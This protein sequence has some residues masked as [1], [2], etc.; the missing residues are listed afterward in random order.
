MAVRLCHPYY[1]L[2]LTNMDWKRQLRSLTARMGGGARWQV[3]LEPSARHLRWPH[4]YAD[5][6][7]DVEGWKEEGNGGGGEV[8]DS[9]L[10]IIVGHLNV[11]TWFGRWQDER[12]WQCRARA[13]PLCSS[14]TWVWTLEGG[15]SFVG[16]GEGG[17]ARLVIIV[18]CSNMPTWLNVWQ[19]EGARRRQQWRS[20]SACHHRRPPQRAN[21]GWASHHRRSPQRANM[22]WM[23]AG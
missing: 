9:W 21:I 4:Q 10:V 18:G 23:L 2:L 20:L 11:P 22:V 19:D 5:R 16:G 6:R 12:T 7:L 3:M 14:P 17:A 8:R 15:R 1:L 13:E